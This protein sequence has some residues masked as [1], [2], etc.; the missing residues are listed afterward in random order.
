MLWEGNADLYRPVQ[1]GSGDE[2]GIVAR[3][4]VGISGLFG[5]LAIPTEA[6]LIDECVLLLNDLTAGDI[7]ANTPMENIVK[8]VFFA[9]GVRMRFDL[10]AIL[11]A[12]RH[13]AKR[14]KQKRQGKE[15]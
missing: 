4:V 10:C 9:K 8:V 1:R 13:G 2:R 6:F 7:L 15:K 11:L 14:R 5:V 12:C 3:I